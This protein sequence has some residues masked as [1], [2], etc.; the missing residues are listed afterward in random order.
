MLTVP[1]WS[2][3]ASSTSG[4]CYVWKSAL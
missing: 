4:A 2:S 1:P 3:G